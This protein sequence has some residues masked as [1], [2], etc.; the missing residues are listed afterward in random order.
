MIFVTGDT[1]GDFSR[2]STDC[3]PEGKNCTKDDF[4]IILGD[5]GGIWEREEN[6][7]ERYWLN[8]LD[9][10]PW[11][12]L[13]LDGN[14]ENHDRMDAMPVEEWHGGRV[15]RVRP[16]VI[17]LMRGQV[18]NIGGSSVFVFG[19]ACSHDISGGILDPGAPQGSVPGTESKLILDGAY[20]ISVPLISFPQ[21]SAGRKRMNQYSHNLTKQGVPFRVRGISWWDRELPSEEEMQEGMENLSQYGNKV[22]YI[23][24]HSPDTMSLRHLGEVEENRL[25]D[26]LLRVK[27]SVQFTKHLFGHMHLYRE[28]VKCK[29]VCL[30]EQI[31]DLARLEC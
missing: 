17:H 16:T 25:T 6:S 3:F 11:T 23:F 2:F 30:Y 1:H 22:D 15:H 31:V 12:T 13:F 19:G 5:F 7:S 9:K 28:L 20:N 29:S 14:H 4:V 24:S 18:F 27:E 8:W 21:T 26:Y 10:K